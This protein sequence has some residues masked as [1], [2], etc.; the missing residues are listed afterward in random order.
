MNTST[1]SLYIISPSVVDWYSLVHTEHTGLFEDKLSLT[2]RATLCIIARLRTYSSWHIK[3]VFQ[4][5]CAAHRQPFPP[6]V[7]TYFAHICGPI[8]NAWTEVSWKYSGLKLHTVT[9]TSWN[10]T[11]LEWDQSVVHVIKHNLS[12]SSILISEYMERKV[13]KGWLS[14]TWKN[15]HWNGVCV[16][17]HVCVTL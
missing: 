3:V 1:S 15:S 11:V 17:V 8:L 13:I 7:K 16:C 4:P 5:K 12:L 14:F 10:E 9:G 6:T 2:N